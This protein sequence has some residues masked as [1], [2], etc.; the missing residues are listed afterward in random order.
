MK[1]ACLSFTSSGGRIAER[2]KITLEHEVDIFNRHFLRDSIQDKMGLMFKQYDGIIFISS[3]GIAVR[4]IAPYLEGKT[5]DPAVVVIDDMGRY[6]ISLLSGHIGGAN[7]LA[8]LAGEAIGAQPI[9]TTASDNRG[10]E[11]VDMFALR[12]NLHIESMEDAKVITAMMIEG[13]GI[14][15][16]SNNGMRIKYSN[17]VEEGAEGYIIVSPAL[18]IEC[19]KPHCILRPKVLNLGIGCRRGKSSDE[20]MAAIERVFDENNLS[21]HSIKIIGSIDVKKDEEGIIEASRIIGCDFKTFTADEIG[22]IQDRFSTSSFV[23]S[24][25]GVTSVAEPSAYLLGGEIIVGR[26]ALN[27]ITIAVSK[28][29]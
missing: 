6:S 8:T 4:L 18:R 1:I 19:E 15:L 9:V 3:T 27:G 11:A 7:K 26:V 5:K 25:V 14:K 20:I 29:V 22:K 24:Q 13:K 10:I 23:E 16:V 21:M 17:L 28:E 2:L 12:N